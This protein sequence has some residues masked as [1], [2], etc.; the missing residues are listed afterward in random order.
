MA[1]TAKLRAGITA[2]G[3]IYVAGIQPQT[4]VWAPGTGRCRPRRGRVAADHP[5]LS[6]ATQQRSDLGQG[7]RARAA[8]KRGARSSGEKA[9]M[10]RCPRAL[11]GCVFAWRIA[12]CGRAEEPEGVAADRVARGR[13][14]ADQIL[15]LDLPAEHLVP[16]SGRRRQAALAHRARLSGAQAGGRARA[17]RRTR[18]ARL[19]SSRHAVHR[20]LRIPDLR[21][22]DDSPLSTTFRRSVPETCRTRR[23]PTQRIPRCGLNAT[24]QTRSQPCAK[25]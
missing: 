21:A 25:G 17:F 15:A 23:L 12:T 13:E 6:A 10:S 3:K 19:P 14:R 1:T 4:L 8:P 5:R 18:M 11:P 2:L 9:R 7:A 20:R 22:G 16:R 24:S